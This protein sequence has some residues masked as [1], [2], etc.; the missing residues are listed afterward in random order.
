MKGNFLCG[1]IH[2]ENSP[3]FLRN[4]HRVIMQ[5]FT[6]G[7]SPGGYGR[8]ACWKDSAMISGQNANGK[9]QLHKTPIP[10]MLAPIPKPRPPNPKDINQWHFMYNS[11]L[12]VA[13]RPD[14]LSHHLM[15]LPHETALPRWLKHPFSFLKISSNY[16]IHTL[17]KKSSSQIHIVA[18]LDFCLGLGPS[19]NPLV[20]NLRIKSHFN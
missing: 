19:Q 18:N 14:T 11:V 6:C 15:F 3:L 10:K 17:H 1:N 5:K 2:T 8:L 4:F 20:R 16:H 13:F 12:S 9:T 7:W